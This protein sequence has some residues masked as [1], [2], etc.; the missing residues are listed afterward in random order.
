MKAAD[1]SDNEGELVWEQAQASGAAGLSRTAA[2]GS[3][4]PQANPAHSRLNQVSAERLGAPSSAAV[5]LLL[6]KAGRSAASASEGS[7]P[8]VP[9]QSKQDTTNDGI[10]RPP[11]MTNKQGRPLADQPA[12]TAGQGGSGSRGM[13]VAGNRQVL[14]VPGEAQSTSQ[15]GSGGGEMET[16]AGDSASAAALKKALLAA[17]DEIV[18]SDNEDEDRA[19]LGSAQPRTDG[20]QQCCTPQPNLNLGKA[21]NGSGVTADAAEPAVVTQQAD[22]AAANVPKAA[23]AEAGAAGPGPG[24][25]GAHR[26]VLQNDPEDKMPLIPVLLGRQATPA[27]PMKEESGVPEPVSASLPKPPAAG[28]TAASSGQQPPACSVARRQKPP[29]PR[30]PTDAG[31]AVTVIPDGAAAARTTAHNGASASTAE[32][33]GSQVEAA[34]KLHR[35]APDEDTQGGAAEED[36]R[37]REDLG[38]A[39]AP[40]SP[41]QYSRDPWAHDPWW[42]SPPAL[43]TS[44]AWQCLIQVLFLEIPVLYSAGFSAH[45]SL[46]CFQRKGLGRKP[47]RTCKFSQFSY[48]KDKASKVSSAGACTGVRKICGRT[49]K[50]VGHGMGLLQLMWLLP[51]HS[52]SRSRRRSNLKPRNQNCQ[53]STSRRNWLSWRRKQRCATIHKVFLPMLGKLL[54]ISAADSEV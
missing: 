35:P 11:T 46:H 34:G 30:L 43:T 39:T 8:S 21:G 29:L 25:F 13:A 1:D 17:E 14:H 33:G 16:I 3:H 23:S 41:V 36:E 54:A 45:A 7:T 37:L 10:V 15:A 47:Q 32:A 12:A 19:A 50:R 2:Q 24:M 9:M 18:I 31:N 4:A 48:R 52:R 53:S 28:S 20:R 49:Q 22:Q 42:A 38:E 40:E 6:H 44:Q 5:P 27:V 26:P 51:V